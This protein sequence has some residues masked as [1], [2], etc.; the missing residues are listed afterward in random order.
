MAKPILISTF[1]FPG[2]GKTFFTSQLAK[3]KG[4]IH[5]NADAVR[6][7][8]FPKSAFT[9]DE[10]KRVFSFMDTAAEYLLRNGH[11]VIYD[12]NTTKRAHRELAPK[13]AKR[14]GADH[15]LVWIQT[16]EA[17]AHER[18]KTRKSDAQNWDEYFAV[19]VSD[20][21]FERMRDMAEPPT[22]DE[23]H[24]VIPGDIPFAKQLDIFDTL[25]FSGSA[26]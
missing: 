14:S 21:I 17:V 10:N 9:L 15:I 25:A 2:S 19:P 26:T 11:S 7:L 8:L 18:L 13:I 1:G 22:G 20:E 12:S 23:P 6:R 5:L 24:L 4:Y 16:P 3:E